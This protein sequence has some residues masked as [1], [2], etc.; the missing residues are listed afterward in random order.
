MT[1]LAAEDLT[2]SQR[3]LGLAAA[4]ACIT[5]TTIA[6]GLTLP[7]LP[8]AIEAQGYS[9]AFNGLNATAGAVAL[10]VT[11][12]F[13]PYAASKLGPIRLLLIC[14]AMA[15]IALALFPVTPVWAWFPLRFLLNTALQGLFVV[16]EVWINTVATER[17][18]GRLIGLYGALATGGFAAGPAL[19]ALFPAGSPIPFYIGSVAILLGLVP[20]LA[21]RAVAP[22]IEQ[23]SMRGM[24][25]I[26]LLAAVPIAASLAHAAAETAASSFLPVFAVREGWLQNDAILLLTAFGVGNVLLQIPIGWMADSMSRRTVLAICAVAACLGGLALP[27]VADSPMALTGLAFLW[28]GAIIGMYTV[29]MTLIGQ[30][31]QGSRLAAA[32]AA[33]SFAYALGSIV[34]PGGAGLAMDAAGQAGLGWFIALVCGVFAVVAISLRRA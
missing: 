26:L 23:V 31:F 17:S 14:F 15:G 1:A 34:G 4:Y 27:L 22:V 33:F 29:G 6:L 3:W 21:A 9:T 7:L 32:S 24:H 18:R 2:L 25:A 13:V 30:L 19:A 11:A 16:S 10:L 28:G 8:L 5:G 20:V 12:P